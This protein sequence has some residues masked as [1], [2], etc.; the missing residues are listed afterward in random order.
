MNLKKILLAAII[1]STF[2]LAGCTG[3][4]NK[5]NSTPEDFYVKVE[6][7]AGMLPD[8]EM[9][10]I[11]KDSCVYEVRKGFR[12]QDLTENRFMFQ[13]TQ[14]EL[15]DIYNI[16][17]L[18]DVGSIQTYQEEVYDRGGSTIHVREKNKTTN[19]SN[20]GMTFIQ[21]NSIENY[22]NIINAVKNITKQKLD[23]Q[24]RTVTLF[25]DVSILN[26]GMIVNITF[27]G[28]S[29]MS[30]AGE[31]K[32]KIDVEV[33]DGQHSGSIILLLT[34]TEVTDRVY[35][36]AYFEIDTREKLSYTLY[37]ENGKIILR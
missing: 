10:F 7:H 14:S 2:P 8:Y 13:L 12:G 24:K 17:L 34:D 5:K 19:V 35:T 21:K 33:L 1:V 32:E 18:N 28:K 22:N 31:V 16:V 37:L 6:F 36:N 4:Q 11:S 15:N 25:I 27:G 29:F 26:S 30:A 20:S 3:S 23:A 9:Y